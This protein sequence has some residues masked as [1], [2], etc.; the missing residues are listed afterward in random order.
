MIGS[1]FQFSHAA[2]LLTAMRLLPAF[3]P[4]SHRIICNSLQT[5]Q[6][7]CYIVQ[8]QQQQWFYVPLSQTTLG[9]R[10]QKKHPPTHTHPDHQ[11]SFISFLHLLQSTASSLFNLH[12]WQSF[13]TTSLQVLFGLPL[14]PAPPTNHCL[15]LINHKIWQWFLT[16]ILPIRHSVQIWYQKQYHYCTTYT[17]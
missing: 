15:L 9:S 8:Q 16:T 4:C 2:R 6:E 17:E 5:C 11:Q 12:A 1:V 3:G 10:Y 7:H 14:G 13:C